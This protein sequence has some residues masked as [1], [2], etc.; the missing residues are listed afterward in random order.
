MVVKKTA[1]KAEKKINLYGIQSGHVARVRAALI[2]KGLPFQ[3]VSV[4]LANRSEAFKKLN[5]SEKIPVLEDVDGTVV[6]DSYYIVEYLD[7][8]YPKTY[9]MIPHGPAGIKV[10]GDVMDIAHSIMD[11]MGPL[12]VEKFNM[13][14]RLMKGGASHRAI[15]LSAQQKKDLEKDVQYKLGRVAQ[16]LGKKKFFT[17]QFSHVDAVYLSVLSTVR[18]VLGVENTPLSAYEKDLLKDKKIAAMFAPQDEKG[19]REI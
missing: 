16:I 12:Y 2:M 5:P 4:N 6:A 19:V 9:K 1:K 18:F 3:H 15:K 8:K 11:A 14:D 10:M 17:G 7:A 13:Y